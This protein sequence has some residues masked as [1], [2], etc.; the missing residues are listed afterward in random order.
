M[1][2]EKSSYFQKSSY[3]EQNDKNFE[4]ENENEIIMMKILY[5]NKEFENKYSENMDTN[6]YD[7]LMKFLEGIKKI[8]IKYEEDNDIKFIFLFSIIKDEANI[9]EMF[10]CSYTLLYPF[11]SDLK[12][13]YQDKDILKEGKNYEYFNKLL[14]DINEIIFGFGL[15]NKKME[16]K[17]NEL[18]SSF[19]AN[20]SSIKKAQSSFSANLS[21]IKEAQNQINNNNKLSISIDSLNSYPLK[22][23]RYKII[24][25]HLYYEKK[26]DYIKELKSGKIIMGNYFDNKIFFHDNILNNNEKLELNEKIYF[27]LEEAENETKTKLIICGDKNIISR[28]FG[29]NKNNNLS[30]VLYNEG[31]VINLINANNNK[32]SVCC[33]ENCIY[34]ISDLLSGIIGKRSN[35]LYDKKYINIIKIT[36]DKIALTSNKC[37]LNGEDKIIFYNCNTKKIEND[38]IKEEY[39]FTISKNNLTIIDVSKYY[40]QKE[41][42][43]LLCGC[44]KYKKYQKNGIL[45]IKFNLEN[46]NVYHKFYETKNFEVYCFCPLLII[47]N[48]YYLKNDPVKKESKYFFVGGFDTNRRRGII[49]LYKINC[50][51][52]I[53]N[54]E[55]EYFQDFKFGEDNSMYFQSF[56]SPINYIIQHQK[57]GNIL[58]NSLDD[59]IY[60]F[61]TPDLSLLYKIENYNEFFSLNDISIVT[62]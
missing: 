20:L 14:D 36:E 28:E 37:L 54:L 17:K 16:E 4:C 10:N 32:A 19:S 53:E 59:K 44:K 33:T 21:S 6:K 8:I 43:I 18:G 22:F 60:L 46:E 12:N 13:D 41:C 58:I 62:T 3:F 42:K 1:N 55:I 11:Y 52:N 40:N 7:N 38:I 48:N 27:T 35:K 49:K 15:E 26:F 2:Q 29:E 5:M 50:N 61:S 56:K 47:E 24:G 51:N 31:K 57:K 25:K 23:K 9:E 30:N 39:S 45:L 34:L